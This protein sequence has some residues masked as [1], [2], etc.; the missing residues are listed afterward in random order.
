M[1]GC[2][3][4]IA[5]AR[6]IVGPARSANATEA[7]LLV[8]PATDEPSDDFGALGGILPAQAI[9]VVFS[10]RPRHERF[11]LPH[12]LREL[13]EKGRI[14][15]P[16]SGVDDGFG[17]LTELARTGLAIRFEFSKL[18][19]TSAES[20]LACGERR[21]V[22]AFNILD[23]ALEYAQAFNSFHG[24]APVG[25]RARVVAK[26][27]AYFSSRPQAASVPLCA[28]AIMSPH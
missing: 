6:A 14:S 20:P 23:G 19:C 22:A 25:R 1:C 10:S 17:A 26:P 27:M 12:S 24:F 3:A 28:L 5:T 13:L 16:L 11:L 18:S 9:G 8:L 2:L 7:I 15:A 21:C 4:F